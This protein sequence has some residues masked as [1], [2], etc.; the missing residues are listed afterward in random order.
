MIF[1]TRIRETELIFAHVENKS[2]DM[3]SAM[4]FRQGVSGLTR[5]GQRWRADDRKSLVALRLE[6]PS[7]DG[8]QI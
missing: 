6:P 2:A 3:E 8:N 1:C 5:L 7:L 4:T